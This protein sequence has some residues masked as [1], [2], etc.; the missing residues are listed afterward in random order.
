MK[1]RNQQVAQIP[2][3]A[4]SQKF[5]RFEYK[6]ILSEHRAN[7]LLSEMR[8][9]L[10][11]DRNS[12]SQGQG[13]TVSSIYFDNKR[14]S[15]YHDKIDGLLQRSK[16]R[17]RTYGSNSENSAPIYLEKKG[18]YNSYVYKTRYDLSQVLATEAAPVEM[19][20]FTARLE[21]L[22]EDDFINNFLYDYHMRR[23]WPRCE[24]KYQRQAFFAKTSSDFRLTVDKKIEAKSSKS[25]MWSEPNG[26]W[27]S[28]A[29]DKAVIEVK[30]HRH[31]PVWFNML[32]RSNGLVREPFSKV[33]KSME[34][35]N[36]AWDEQ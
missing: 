33:C 5:K 27:V 16:Y 26:K 3:G 8:R 23:F 30:F 19:T 10:A 1:N 34:A 24:V 20:E 2:S 29:P 11:Q 13:Y 36:L 18:K 31:I 21:D 7:F 22:S 28:V 6:Y 14:L 32:V 15:A 12:G 25:L 17:L 4:L 9:F 35:L